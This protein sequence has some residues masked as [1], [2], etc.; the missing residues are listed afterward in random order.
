[1]R[2]SYIRV[3]IVEIVTL[4]CLWWLQQMLV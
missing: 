2:A 1:V 3:I 4:A